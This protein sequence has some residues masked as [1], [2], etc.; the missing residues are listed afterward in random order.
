M[1]TSPSLY[2]IMLGY[3][4]IVLAL[5]CCS[6]KFAYFENPGLDHIIVMLVCLSRVIVLTKFSLSERSCRVDPF[7]VHEVPVLLLMCCAQ[8][9]GDHSQ[10]GDHVSSRAGMSILCVFP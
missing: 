1:S 6:A 8:C 5:S 2:G 10:C 7:M 3:R 4:D 9:C